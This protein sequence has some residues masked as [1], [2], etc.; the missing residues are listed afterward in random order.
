MAKIPTA[1]A[2]AAAEAERKAEELLNPKAD[3]VVTTQPTAVEPEVKTEPTAPVVEEPVKPVQP[4]PVVVDDALQERID[5]LKEFEQESQQEI[6]KLKSNEGRMQKRISELEAEL[7]EAK[8]QPHADNAVIQTETITA[9]NN[10]LFSE[11]EREFLGD[12]YIKM[13]EKIVQDAINNARANID[14][15]IDERLNPLEQVTQSN[16][17]AVFHDRVIT[18]LGLDKDRFMK[19]DNSALFEQYLQEEDS[20]GNVLIDSLQK[21]M[22]NNDV[23]R[24]AKIYEGFLSTLKQPTDKAPARAVQPDRIAGGNAVLSETHIPSMSYAEVAQAYAA[25]QLTKAQKDVMIAEL[26]EAQLRNL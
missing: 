11:E 5:K 24:T 7:E 13:A 20:S 1:V 17:N 23:E 3:E 12:D 15:R 8:K 25:G 9:S 18:R 21:H 6:H 26:D 4:E 22:A 19:I 10:K 14:K 16:N 2:E